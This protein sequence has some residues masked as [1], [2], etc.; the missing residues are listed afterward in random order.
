MKPTA[1][2]ILQRCKDIVEG[3]HS[4]PL[5]FWIEADSDELAKPQYIFYY[6]KPQ[7]GIEDHIA[8]IF[9]GFADQ[10]PPHTLQLAA[11]LLGIDKPEVVLEWE[12]KVSTAEPEDESDVAFYNDF[13]R[14]EVTAN[15]DGF[16]N[17]FT[18]INNRIDVIKMSIPEA[19]ARAWCAK[20]ITEITTPTP[21]Q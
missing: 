14:A 20:R 7:E 4:Q 10:I 3:K 1:A 18:F 17:A 11:R 5:P 9:W 21:K 16:R 2:Q 6:A 15:H 12:R 19:E 8:L 13:I